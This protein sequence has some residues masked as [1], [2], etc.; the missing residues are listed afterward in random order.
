MVTITLDGEARE[1]REGATV[2]EAAREAG[3]DIPTLCHHEALGPYGA[4][5]LCLVEAE[6]PALRRSIVTA[7]TLAASPGLSV[8]TS[9]AAVRGARRIVFELLLGRAPSSEALRAL[10]S[11]HGV[12]RTRFGAGQ[13]DD[14]CV[15]CGL[16]VRVCTDRIGAS[17]IAF[18]GRGQRRRVTAEFGEPSELCIGCGS[19][20]AVCPTGA[21]RLEDAGGE[22][23]IRLGD[24]TIAR[25]TL[26]R[27]SS[28]GAPFAT[29]K[30]LDALASRLREQPEADVGG[31]CPECR[32]VR[33]AAALAAEP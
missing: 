2:L 31:R 24:L 4:C 21:I 26:V 12:E 25:F 5:R 1:V 17:A 29:R 33:Y 28:C 14:A 6:G 22:R 11:R 7:C 18:A 32:R 8:Q 30:L 19:C 10:A 23:T 3:V 16:C 15:R 9:S 20:A 27:C 13:R